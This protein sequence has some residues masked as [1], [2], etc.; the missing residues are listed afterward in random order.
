MRGQPRKDKMGVGDM[1]IMPSPKIKHVQLRTRLN[2]QLVEPQAIIL[3]EVI[4]VEH[5]HRMPAS[6]GIWQLQ[7]VQVRHL[8][9][10]PIQRHATQAE[11]GYEQADPAQAGRIQLTQTITQHQ[12]ATTQPTR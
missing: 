3:G 8:M 12:H 7:P 11:V 2:S 1:M 10:E 5:S 9:V 4:P 6:F